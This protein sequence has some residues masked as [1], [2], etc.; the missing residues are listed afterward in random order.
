MLIGIQV[1]KTVLANEQVITRKRWRS[2][3]S[4]RKKKT[5]QWFFN[6]TKFSEELFKRSQQIAWLA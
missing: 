6:I 3:C 4:C 2:K 1:E 5:S